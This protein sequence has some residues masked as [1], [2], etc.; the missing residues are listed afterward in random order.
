MK[1]SHSLLHDAIWAVS[2]GIVLA[3]ILSVFS[4]GNFWLGWLKAAFFCVLILFGLIRV[5][6][7]VGAHSVLGIMILVA[8]IIR[9]GFG[10]FLNQGLPELGFDNP[11]QNA[12]YVFS[13]AAERDQAA[14]VIAQSE[15]PWMPQFKQFRAV[16]QYGGLLAVSAAV[17]KVFSPDVHR[18]LFIVL[19]SAFSMAA[20]LAFLFA[21]VQKKWG[22]KVALIT[23][24]IFALYPDGILLGSSQMREPILIGLTCLLFWIILSWKETPVRTLFVGAIVSG[25]IA[26]F[27]IPGAG[28]ALFVTGGIVFIEW[29]GLQKSRKTR[30][31]SLL[32]CGLIIG[33]VALVGWLWLRD[34]LKYEFYLTQSASGWLNAL[35]KQYGRKIQI[36]LITMYGLTQ[37]L[38]PAA[39][40]DPSLPLWQG[41]AIF[42]AAG[43]YFALPFVIY[44]FFAV[45]SA[46]KEE[47]RSL[48]VFLSLTFAVWVLISS[49]RAGGD[50]W[51][52]P[53]YRTTF[54]PWMAILVGW[55]WLRLR[56]Q[57]SPWFWRILSIEIVSVLFFLYWYFNRTIYS[58]AQIPFQ[59]MILSII[60]IS[61][62]IFI[63]GISWDQKKKLAKTDHDSQQI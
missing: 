17:Y 57:R 44:G 16:D 49:L 27:S 36:P 20:G 47:N 8:F 48:L 33:L 26:F 53:R 41:L 19:I 22:I 38:L 29:F 23:G 62:I 60:G 55:V 40:I 61:L 2:G 51:D 43:W 35:V 5:W 1:K 31:I 30:V 14:F 3:A 42:R 52:N 50:Q 37:P 4:P 10:I 21:A 46:K 59:V 24:W 32:L 12:G 18:P 45:I 63:G 11:V 58:F 6:R 15:E 7:L 28:A 13:D 56:T 9:I 25:V 34:G 54:L 39:I